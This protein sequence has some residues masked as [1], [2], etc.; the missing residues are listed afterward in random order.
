MKIKLGSQEV[1]VPV[2][3]IVIVVV[4]AVI[5]ANRWINTDN[6][7]TAAPKPAAVP[8]PLS[9]PAPLIGEV[10]RT[11]WLDPNREY[12]ESAFFIG[13]QEIARFK[14]SGNKV[15]D[16]TGKIPDGVVKFNNQTEETYGEEN[17]VNNKRNGKYREYYVSNNQ[18]RKEAY[19]LDG[20]L[21]SLTEYFIDGKKRMEF[22][23]NDALFTVTAVE[24]GV[25]KVYNRNGSLKYE[26]SLT[27]R[28]RGGFNRSYN[29][30]GEL[31]AENTFDEFGNKTNSWLKPR[32]EEEVPVTAP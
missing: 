4:I 24:N 10:T 2:I 12:E 18:L 32:E 31:V 22:D 1:E 3:V 29:I 14:S 30:A 23:Y 15:F 6:K 11:I 13:D 26:W 20:E 21:K 7:K 19:Y 17:Y 5:M 16:M 9:E 25:G 28:Q 27:N 8:A